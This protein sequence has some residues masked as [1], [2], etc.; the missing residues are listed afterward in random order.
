MNVFFKF[1]PEVAAPDRERV[2]RAVRGRTTR[3]VRRLFPDTA[4]KELIVHYLVKCRT[5]TEATTLVAYLSSLP[6]IEYAETQ[7]KRSFQ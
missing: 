4:V 5:A 3:K 1:R 7:V 2:L 6:E